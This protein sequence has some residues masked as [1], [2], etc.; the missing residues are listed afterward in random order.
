MNDDWKQFLAGQGAPFDRARHVDETVLADVSHGGLIAVTGEDA[1]AFLQGQ[2]STDLEK[3]TP[4]SSQLSSWSNSKGRVVTALRVFQRDDAIHLALH[5]S[6]LASVLKRLSLYVLR[7][8]AELT[9]ASESLA[10]FGLAGPEATKLIQKVGLAVPV[11]V[12]DVTGHGGVQVIR[13]HGKTH[14]YALLGPSDALAS[15]WKLSQAAGARPVNEGQW[16]L[17]KILA[18][19]PTVYP[20]TSEHFV[21]Q[22]LGLDELGAIDFKKGCYIGQEVIARSH[23]RGAVKRHLVHA[24]SAAPAVLKPGM[25]L[26]VRGEDASVAE[27][28]DAQRDDKGNW[29]M[30]LV[31]QDAHREAALVHT[32]SGAAIRVISVAP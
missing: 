5:Q 22:M 21:A 8:K 15:L 13:L 12:N 19:E 28:V 14:R 7:A 32:P 1:R 6:L 11:N 9:D 20:E 31:I 25:E 16:S 24:Q 4:G 3:L 26:Q 10:R 2:L 29:R 30:L 18:G 23:Y 17:L 27:I